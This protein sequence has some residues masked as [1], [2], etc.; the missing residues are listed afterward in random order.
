METR[1]HA[2]KI[3]GAISATC[4]FPFG[5]DELYA[6]D[7]AQ[8]HHG[9]HEMPALRGP[10][11]PKVFTTAEL[12]TLAKLADVIIPPTDTPGGAEAGVPEYI[13]LIASGSSELAAA[14]H[15]GL[16]WLD[17]RSRDS[18]DKTFAELSEHE[19]IE[20]L[21]PLSDAADRGDF[22]MAGARFFHDVKNMTADG[23]YTSRIGLIEEL[24]YTGNTALDH[25][26]E[27]TLP[28]H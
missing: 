23:Y 12:K 5:A 8:L 25:F 21:Q 1:R 15:A 26:P 9:G 27:F 22:S 20:I 18:Y 13:D 3:I 16:E 17:K 2:L 11:T 6:Q 28:E 7:V 4:A 10:Y 24:G 14:L 19:Q